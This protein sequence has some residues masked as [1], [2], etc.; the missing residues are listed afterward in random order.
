MIQFTN[1]DIGKNMHYIF[2][3]NKMLVIRKW[4]SKYTN[5]GSITKH[6]LKVKNDVILMFNFIC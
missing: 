5:K 2:T 4:S 1:T 6:A 3:Q